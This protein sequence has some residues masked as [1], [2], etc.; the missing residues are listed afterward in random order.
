MRRISLSAL[1]FF[2]GILCGFSQNKSTN[3]Q[4][5]TYK[6]KTLKVEEA[7]LV[8]SY[9]TQDGNNSAVTGGVGTEK[10]TDFSNTFDLKLSRYDYGNR[11]HTIGLE[12]GVDTYTSASS[13]MIEANRPGRNGSTR[14]SASYQD[15]R[16]YP[17][18]SWQVADEKRGITFGA[19]GSFSTEYDY[20]S[21]GAGLNFSKTSKD[22]SREF[23]AKLGAFLD[24][25]M[26]IYPAELRPPGY[27]TG[28]HD[29]ENV[30]FTPRNTFNLALSFAQIIN[31][32]LQMSFMVEPSY[33]QG[34]LATKYQRVYFN[35]GS[36]KPEN[37]PDNRKKLPL[38]MRA[39]YFAGDRLIVRSFYRFY[40][41]DWGLKAHTISVEPVVKL[42]PYFSVSPFYRFYAQNGIKYFAAYQQQTPT[43]DFFT[44]DYDL[45]KLTSHSVGAG[46]R[47]VGR[48]G[49][50]GIRH[51][52]SI[53][54]RY[55]YYN[56]STALTS[57]IVTVAMKFK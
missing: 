56:R 1:V 34:L 13:D 24:T 17:S 42:S 8:S 37:L 29:A 53:E 6:S 40:A 45:S 3:E 48:D 50:M 26:V 20:T 55:A 18:V 10:L 36:A 35:N 22:K 7:N 4:D 46:I 11:K 33:Q 47:F 19:N 25:W 43:A 28:G 41:D 9:Y 31:Q 57:H 16:V 52:N 5:T 14:T 2:L 51:W 54:L 27:G 44:S 38:S 32:R 30:D 23:S 21:K 49:V 15:V 39:T 12:V